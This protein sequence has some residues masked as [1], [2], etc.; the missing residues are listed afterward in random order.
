MVSQ[1]QMPIKVSWVMDAG[2]CKFAAFCPYPERVGAHE[3]HQKRSV[4]ADA[5]VNSERLAGAA[6]VRLSS[7]HVISLPPP[8]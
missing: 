2:M 1:D 6:S 4:R 7:S 8:F 5:C 3:A